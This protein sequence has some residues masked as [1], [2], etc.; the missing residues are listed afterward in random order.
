MRESRIGHS[1]YALNQF[2][3]S[4]F[5]NQDGTKNEL[6][7]GH[8]IDS[9]EAGLKDDVDGQLVPNDP[10]LLV[11]PDWEDDKFD[12][13]TAKFFGNGP[14]Y[15]NDPL[16]GLT[17][18]EYDDVQKWRWGEIFAGW[19]Q[20][21]PNVRWG[22]YQCVQNY[23]WGGNPLTSWFNN[24]QPEGMSDEEAEAGGFGPWLSVK[25]GDADS[26]RGWLYDL[27]DVLAVHCYHERL[28]G[29]DNTFDEDDIR[30]YHRDEI[31]HGL[32]LSQTRYGGRK[33]VMPYVAWREQGL[34]SDGV[35][36]NVAGGGLQ[37]TLDADAENYADDLYRFAVFQAADGDPIPENA[38]KILV[39]RY[40][41]L[42]KV[43]T[44]RSP[45]PDIMSTWNYKIS[46]VACRTEDAR[47]WL[48]GYDD[49]AAA[50]PGR[51]LT[52]WAMWAGVP[53]DEAAW[54]TSG[55][56]NERV[57]PEISERFAGKL[58]FVPALRVAR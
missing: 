24:Q 55:I 9:L 47:A 43:V 17:E 38:T 40:D 31:R 39:D 56:L 7:L 58:G 42:N 4:D 16:D 57:G 46:S 3:I 13:G 53:D 25:Q 6:L 22:C 15:P 44:L 20:A 41:A 54:A 18:S 49:A 11:L 30:H 51:S 34:T 50:G 48:N 23:R 2:R 35:A 45:Y 28:L 19:R 12:S 14:K 26:L 10:D 8:V 33:P 1:S 5:L 32:W 36:M 21:R 29:W 37:I 27:A 52:P